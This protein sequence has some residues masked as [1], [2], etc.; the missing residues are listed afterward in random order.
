MN[1]M[2]IIDIS[3]DNKEKKDKFM[4]GIYISLIVLVVL[5]LITYF[6]LYDVL[7]PFIKV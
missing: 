5:A 1:D 3:D 7:K 6:F 2:D 4:V